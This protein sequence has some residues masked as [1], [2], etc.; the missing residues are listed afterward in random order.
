MIVKNKVHRQV[1]I[2]QVDSRQIDIRQV[3]TRQVDTWHYLWLISIDNFGKP[4]YASV[5]ISCDRNYRCISKQ[6]GK[7]LYWKNYI[8]KKHWKFILE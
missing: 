5:G 2:R 3:D 1:D 4:K 8:I 7:H 6:L